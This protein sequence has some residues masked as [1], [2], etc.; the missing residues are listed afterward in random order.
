MRPEPELHIDAEYVIETLRDL[1]R[2]NSINPGFSG[3]TTDEAEVAAYTSR[4][5]QQLGMQ[6]SEYSVAPG[7]PSVVGRV[8]GGGGPSLMLY[9]HY[10]TVG[11]EGMDDPFGAAVRDGRVHGRGAYDMK[12]GLAACLGAV[13]AL[14]AA[15]VAPDGDVVVV[16]VADEEVA[17]LG[18]QEVLRHVRTDAAVVT[19]PT[20]LQLCVA[21]KGFCWI[22][23]RT[24]GEAA[25]GSRF[26]LGVDANMRMG[27][28]LAE[29]GRLE[30][31]L[32]GRPPHA[33]VGPPSLHAATLQGGTGPSTYAARC[34]L[35]IERRTIPGETAIQAVSE[36]QAVVDHLSRRDPAFRAELELSLARDSFEVP[37]SAAIA[38]AAR[39]AAT[40]V[41]GAAPEEVG[42][43]HWMDAAFLAAA[44]IETVIIGPAGAGAHA[45]VEWV[46]AASVVQLSRLLTGMVRTYQQ[47]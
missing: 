42:Q 20:E 16:A 27:S 44:G 31:E 47:T 7:R 19:E 37:G 2:I 39:T 9:A 41:L 15:A 45:A 17:S 18:I 24:L 29:L 38:R 25:H 10:D 35:Q 11:V 28:F 40:E 6:V 33:M 4:A 23:V 34:D 1:V 21:H 22:N 8:R 36:I 46:D 5:M 3:G 14:R 13:Q 12:G 32:R 30:E 43:S 26:D